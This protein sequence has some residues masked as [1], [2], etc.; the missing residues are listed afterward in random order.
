MCLSGTRASDLGDLLPVQLEGLPVPPG[1]LPAV[2]RHLGRGRGGHRGG[3][4]AARP[5]RRHD[6]A[7]ARELGELPE[8]ADPALEHVH[9]H[10]PEHGVL[11]LQ[12]QVVD[13]RH[14]RH[15][16]QRRARPAVTR[17]AVLPNQ[18]GC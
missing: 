6:P 3:A 18:V 10:V 13:A 14:G 11:V 7:R 17:Q 2:A 12:A 5:P 8:L 1:Q 9:L 15:G 4:A 16:G